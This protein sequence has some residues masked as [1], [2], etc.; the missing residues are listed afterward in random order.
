MTPIAD[1]YG[2]QVLVRLIPPTGDAR[3][4][5]SPLKVSWTTKKATTGTPATAT[6]KIYNAAPDSIQAMQD[7]QSVIELWVGY[8]GRNAAGALDPNRIG[9]LKLIWRGNPVPFGVKVE[10]QP[11]NTVM[12]VEASDGGAITSTGYVSISFATQTTP[13]QVL[14]EA[15]RQ[16]G[17]PADS[18]SY[19]MSPVFDGGFRFQGRVVDLFQRLAVAT[20]NTW[21]IR[22]G[23][24]VFAGGDEAA[25]EI[26]LIA[27]TTGMVGSPTPKSDGSVE[28]KILINPAVRV[29]GLV[30][31]QSVQV[32]GVYKVQTLESEGDSREGPFYMKLTAIKQG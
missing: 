14:Q 19:P 31:V 26:V 15:L 1:L 23:A 5:R 8:S 3:E 18:V 10:S 21:Y 30:E 17:I 27:S 12:T 24:F 29:G 22:D 7:R 11:P 28:V 2:R 13:A 32:N 25:G 20:G 4:L 6:I 9:P 16:T